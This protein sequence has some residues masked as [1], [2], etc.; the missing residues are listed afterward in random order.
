MDVCASVQRRK[1]REPRR[2][3]IRK[4]VPRN[5]ERERHSGPRGWLRGRTLPASGGNGDGNGNGSGRKE[6]GG[7]RRETKNESDS[8][9]RM[10]RKTDTEGGRERKG[11]GVPG[12]P[13]RAFVRILY[14]IPV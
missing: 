1:I 9:C 14:G 6:N 7:E 11:G 4:G 10:E 3:R 12:S 5:T 2:K 13:E 8:G